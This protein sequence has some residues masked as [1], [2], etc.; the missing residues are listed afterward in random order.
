[1]ARTLALDEGLE[2]RE[3][4][5]AFRAHRERM[6]AGGVPFHAPAGAPELLRAIRGSVTIALVTNAPSAGLP[7]I[8]DALGLA[9]AFDAVV[10]DAGKPAGLPGIV[11]RL[12][13][14]DGDATD[15]RRVFAVGD[16]WENDLAPLARRGAMTGHVDRHFS[17][18]G[19][20]TYRTAD[21]DALVPVIRT[22]ADK[23]NLA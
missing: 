10:A 20:P 11:G 18:A 19:D 8:L 13:A 15:F 6:S 2:D 7:T 9:D 3:V 1:M 4:S 12:L 17:R 22:W 16:I 14:D 21:F 5:A 23:W